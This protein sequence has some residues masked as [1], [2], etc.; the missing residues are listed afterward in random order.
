MVVLVGPPGSGKTTIGRALAARLEVTVRDTDEDI[1]AQS[2]SSIT[3]LF[4]EHGEPHFRQLERAA[5]RAAL[6]EHD[7]VLSIGG[8]AVVDADTRALLDGR[9]VVFLDVSVAEA[10]NRVGMSGPRPLLLGNVRG[11]LRQLMDERRP[12]YTQVATL[13]VDTS[14]R[15]PDDI[16]SEILPAVPRWA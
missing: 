2:G 10:S 5:V 14:G 15:T 13:T 8:G 12:L 4:V 3:E 11:R 1:E 16:V 9:T 7:G 6:A